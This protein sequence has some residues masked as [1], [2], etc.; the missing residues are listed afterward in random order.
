MHSRHKLGGRET[1]RE[2]ETRLIICEGCTTIKVLTAV[3]RCCVDGLHVAEEGARPRDTA[4]RTHTKAHPR[5]TLYVHVY[6]FVY[7]DGVF[8]YSDGVFVYP[9]GAAPGRAADRRANHQGSFNHPFML[10]KIV[11]YQQQ[12]HQC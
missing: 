12:Q 6:V 7:P 1:T 11:E 5:S 9:D 8:V 2:N 4:T 3:A 10:A